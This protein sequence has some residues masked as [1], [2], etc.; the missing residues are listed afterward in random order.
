[1]KIILTMESVVPNKNSRDKVLWMKE[2]I[3]ETG[4]SFGQAMTV[5][6]IFSHNTDGFQKS[7]KHVLDLDDLYKSDCFGVKE[8][9]HFMNVGKRNNTISYYIIS[10]YDYSLHKVIDGFTLT[11][12]SIQEIVNGAYK[13]SEE[14]IKQMAQYI[15]IIQSQK[16]V[17]FMSEGAHGV[18][19]ED[20]IEVPVRAKPFYNDDQPLFKI[21][22]ITLKKA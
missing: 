19:G 22:F 20:K 13:P 7:K 3:N 21:P 2:F 1:M 8:I 12:E 17:A 4:F 9:E 11:Q 18:L 16:P 14:E 10:E 6:N 15:M 5:A